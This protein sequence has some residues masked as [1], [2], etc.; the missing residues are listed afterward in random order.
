MAENESII[1]LKRGEN[2]EERAD[3]R[4][5]R[6]FTVNIENINFRLLIDRQ[7][8]EN[9]DAESDSFFLHDHVSAELFACISGSVT[10]ATEEG[11]L[12]LNGGDLAVVP[13]GV[14]HCMLS[15]E[16]GTESAVISF[17]CDRRADKSN[18]DL[19]SVL[20]TFICGDSISVFRG[21]KEVCGEIAEIVRLGKAEGSILPAMK[22]VEL[23]IRLAEMATEKNSD[24][25][26]KA[27]EGRYDIQRMMRLD[28]VIASSYMKKLSMK[29]IADELYI[30]SRQLDRIVRKRYG[31]TLHQVIMETRIR[32]AERML[33]TT[34]MAVDRIGSTVGFSSNAGF[35][36]EF[37]RY[38]GMTPA[39]YRKKAR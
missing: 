32:S 25:A 14:P 24:F 31:K 28:T 29:E 10:L 34:N 15:V 12:T 27:A 18:T 26:D 17:I 33:L 37:S 1:T 38:F 3:T 20:S 39:E 35:Y 16:N 22:T 6:E 2:V 5:I 23:L 4:Q 19:Y 36:R 21:R 7:R 9:D 11:K 30:S 13:P 8:K